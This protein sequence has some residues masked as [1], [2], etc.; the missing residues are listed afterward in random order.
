[1]KG[2]TQL[3]A[4]R[5]DG[6]A[7]SVVFVETNP[8]LFAAVHDWHEY[9]PNR[10]QVRIEAND[11]PDTADLRFL[12][13]LSVMV[14]GNDLDRV[15]RVGKACERAKASRVITF[16]GREVNDRFETVEMTDTEG[17]VT[18]PKS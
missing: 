5:K 1:M 12:V 2:H 14:N 13:G 16:V 18:W 7:P 3:I 8:E 10:A 15:R 9:A 4:M 11:N 6:F 17:R